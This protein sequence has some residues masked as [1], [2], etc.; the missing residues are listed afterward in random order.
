MKNSEDD[1]GGGGTEIPEE[2]RHRKGSLGRNSSQDN[3]PENEPRE[4][5]YTDEQL[6]A[7]KRLLV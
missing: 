3:P 5:E 2:V 6:V 7:V 1:D 4:K